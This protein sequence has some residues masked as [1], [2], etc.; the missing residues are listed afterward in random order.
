MNCSKVITWLTTSQYA[1]CLVRH[2]WLCKSAIIQRFSSSNEVCNES[3]TLKLPRLINFTM[4]E[5]SKA[6]GHWS[7]VHRHLASCHTSLK[8]GRRISGNHP[9]Q[10]PPD[11]PIHGDFGCPSS[12][13]RRVHDDATPPITDRLHAESCVIES[14]DKKPTSRP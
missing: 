10:D 14:C 9:M 5:S 2:V 1:Q 7:C 12:P 4:F 11:W 6:C 3:Y 13:S 8:M